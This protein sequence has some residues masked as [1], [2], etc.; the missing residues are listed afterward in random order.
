MNCKKILIA[1]TFL[2]PFILLAQEPT[3]GQLLP[4][5]LPQS[6]QPSSGQPSVNQNMPRF[7]L[8]PGGGMDQPP[9]P[10]DRQGQENFKPEEQPDFRDFVDPRELKDA[11]RQI[12]EV[13]REANRMVKKA[14][15][16]KGVESA[17]AS[18]QEL[19]TKLNEH[20]SALKNA[21][22]GSQRE[23]LQEFHDGRFW[24]VIEAAR[25]QIEFPQEV[26]QIERELKRVEKLL[27][28]KGLAV[29]GLN[30]DMVRTKVTEIKEA[31]A[32]AKSAVAEGNFEEAREAMQ[33]I[34]EGSHPGEIF[35]VI[36]QLREITRRLKT[37]R[38]PEIKAE[39]ME[40]LAPVFES[41]NEGDFREANRS[42]SELSG[43][44]F[45]IISRLQ[46]SPQINSELRKKID[47][48]EEKF[49]SRMEEKQSYAPFYQ[50]QKASL[51][52][53]VRGLLGL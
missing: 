53:S 46:R 45:Q 1:G 26:K 43:E 11:F 23:A 36:Q 31:L 4:P 39:I 42:L 32:R 8:P 34:Y 7:P 30:L 51:L 13:R 16:L 44:F 35:G 15:L 33:V 18:L 14:K 24:E 38:S 9:Q 48:L 2:F 50:E 10:P 29:E 41:A 27:T 5:P 25:I 21:D 3:H 49:K 19:L 40:I 20:E 22:P 37:L 47:N 28:G 52:D 6:P 12:K 17:L